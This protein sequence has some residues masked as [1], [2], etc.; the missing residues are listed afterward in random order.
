M[1]EPDAPG[2]DILRYTATFTA[3]DEYD[4]GDGCMWVAA[5]GGVEAAEAPTSFAEGAWGPWLAPGDRIAL[6]ARRV[7]GPDG[8]P[9]LTDVRVL[10]PPAGESH[11]YVLQ[12]LKRRDANGEHFVV[13]EREHTGVH[14]VVAVGRD[15]AAG[16]VADLY[17]G[18]HPDDLVGR[19]RM[20]VLAR[21][22]LEDLST[23]PLPLH[24]ATLEIARPPP[25]SPAPEPPL[26][27]G[28]ERI[29][30]LQ[31]CY[32]MG[33]GGLLI[34]GR[35]EA[36]G[37][38]VD[39]VVGS[40]GYRDMPPTFDFGHDPWDLANLPRVVVHGRRADQHECNGRR[41]VADVRMVEP[42]AGSPRRGEEDS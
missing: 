16:A 4:D 35:C 42:K 10:G 32:E 21:L 9:R 36:T 31:P 28:F 34:H 1:A 15:G 14:Y 17:Y 8:R 25:P 27:A 23:Y 11:R 26:E 12:G 19:G 37:E 6:E 41:R 22:A 2:P 3:Y 38:A 20:V 29:V 18:L 5:P 13:G 24:N 30:I 40:P 7:I 39:I 33:D